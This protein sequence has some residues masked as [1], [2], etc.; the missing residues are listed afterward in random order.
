MDIDE[1]S[2][3]LFDKL[4]NQIKGTN[5]EHIIKDHFGGSFSNQII[6]KDCPHFSLKE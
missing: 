1:F 6:C 5:S 4:E 2:S 3:I